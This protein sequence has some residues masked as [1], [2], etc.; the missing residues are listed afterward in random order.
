[1]ASYNVRL[2]NG[3][4]F[5]DVTD[6]VMFQMLEQLNVRDIE[7]YETGEILYQSKAAKAEDGKVGGI[8]R[9]SVAVRGVKEYDEPI[10][11]PM[12]KEWLIIT[13]ADIPTCSYRTDD[14]QYATKRFERSV[15]SMWYDGPFY[16]EVRLYHNGRVI[17]AAVLGHEIVL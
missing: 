14:E 5:S 7:S 3:A 16:D 13:H 17:R 11:L 15:S 12:A 10:V 8:T 2:M 6:N 1:M 4:F 9:A